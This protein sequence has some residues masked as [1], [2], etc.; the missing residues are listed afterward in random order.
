MTISRDQYISALKVKGILNDRNTKVLEII[1]E[2]NNCKSTSKQIAEKLNLSHGT[3]NLRFGRLGRLISNQIGIKPTQRKDGTYRWWSIIAD[4]Q[5]EPN[6]FN[7]ILHKN[8]IEAL[9]ELGNF[10]QKTYLP[11]EINPNQ[12]D[13]I[14]GSVRK[15]FVNAY[16][17]NSI[18]REECIKHYGTTCKVCEMNFEA[19]YG[20]IGSN[21]IH[22]HHKEQISNKKG[23]EYKVDPIS[24][25]IPVCPNCHSM[26]HRKNPPFTID[27]LK[28][29]LNNDV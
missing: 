19:V 27:E 8:L 15:I 24:D 13:L 21:Y 17:R 12:T 25:L 11:E 3:I 1:Y 14:E 18:A 2:S 29:L 5:R 7:W 26:L 28:S 22:V 9:I 4:G 6:G 16:E 10:S 23:K 20:K